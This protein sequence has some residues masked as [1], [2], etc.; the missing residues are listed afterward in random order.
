MIASTFGGLVVGL[1]LGAVGGAAF[2]F[3]GG[4]S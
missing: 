3:H 4:R 2:F 1:I